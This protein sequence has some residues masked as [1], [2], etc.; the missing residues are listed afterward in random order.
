M[1]QKFKI[2]KFPKIFNKNILKT[3]K[4]KLILVMSITKRKST[5]KV[6]KF[7]KKNL[8]EEVNL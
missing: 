4:D 8:T 6:N 1:T 7:L 5:K 2:L 3:L